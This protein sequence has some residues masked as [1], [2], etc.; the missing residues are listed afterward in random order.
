MVEAC[1]IV[2]PDLL[3]NTVLAP[4]KRILA[5][6]AGDWEKAHLEGCRYY[7]ERFYVPLRD[8]ADLVIVSCGGFPKDITSFRRIKRWN[9]GAGRSGT[10]G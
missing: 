5:V 7:A 10:V 6:F 8:K 2:K 3:L 4:D 9:T 1:A